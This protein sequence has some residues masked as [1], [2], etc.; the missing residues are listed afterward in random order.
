VHLSIKTHRRATVAESAG[1]TIRRIIP[2]GFTEQEAV[3]W[4]RYH[5]Q[6]DWRLK[7]ALASV[8]GFALIILGTV[9]GN[10][11]LESSLMSSMIMRPFV[12]VTVG[13]LFAY[14]ANKV[15]S[16]GFS[17]KLSIIHESLSMR[18]SQI[19]RCGILSFALAGLMIY[20][21]AL[22]SSID[23]SLSNSMIRCMMYLT[24]IFAGGLVL[25]GI[26]LVSHHLLIILSIVVGKMLGLLG[27]YLI[28]SPTYLYSAYPAAQQADAGVIMITI[29]TVID[30]II[31]PCWLYRYF[32]TPYTAKLNVSWKG[33]HG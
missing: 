5:L 31:L 9:G 1:A 26:T 29:M 10:A 20:F 17:V 30:M 18:S 2:L 11:Y 24:F 23:A 15:A 33:Q 13:L 7:F 21:W 27:A 22:P 32:R 4:Y 14:A 16:S 6:G 8:S 3:G 19:N 25:T 28:L 12:Y